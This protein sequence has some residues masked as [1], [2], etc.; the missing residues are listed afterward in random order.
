MKN[1][2]VWFFLLFCIFFESA[3]IALPLTLALFV[4]LYVLYQEEWVLITAFFA[5]IIL[6]I[7]RLQAI[8]ASSIFF[9]TFLGLILLYERK[10]EVRTFPFAGFASLVGSILYLGIFQHSYII[11]QAVVSAGFSFI[12]FYC[13]RKKTALKERLLNR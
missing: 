4:V 8:G 3:F 13:M 1:K 2:R 10:F 12:L 6:D 9:L 5:G 11:L 7:L